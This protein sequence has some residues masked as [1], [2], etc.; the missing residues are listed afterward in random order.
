MHE[1]RHPCEVLHGVVGV[2]RDPVQGDA[3]YAL[4][5][6][7]FDA[8]G[9]FEP[10]VC[11]AARWNTTRASNR[12]GIATIMQREKAVQGGVGRPRSRREA[13]AQDPRR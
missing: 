11:R 8:V 13:R 12:M 10:T 9:L 1:D 7:D 2:E 4:D 3:V 6:L 5:L